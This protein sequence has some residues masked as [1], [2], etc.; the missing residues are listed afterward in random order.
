[1]PSALP[2]K[3][4]YRQRETRAPHS[5]AYLSPCTAPKST[6]APNHT[7]HSHKLTPHAFLAK[8][9]LPIP[10]RDD[11][12]RSILLEGRPPAPMCRVTALGPYYAHAH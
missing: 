3:K 6:S 5:N 2:R 9:P 12:L 4:Q 8:S 7:Q 10:T 11:Q 1:M